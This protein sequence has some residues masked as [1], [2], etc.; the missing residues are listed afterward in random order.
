M[1]CYNRGCIHLLLIISLQGCVPQLVSHLHYILS[2]VTGV[3]I[4][5]GG[6][7][8]IIIG[9]MAV[10]VGSLFAWFFHTLQDI[11]ILTY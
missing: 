10:V 4:I 3:S 7:P 11:D 2:V 1:Q 5:A 9:T 6:I 8:I